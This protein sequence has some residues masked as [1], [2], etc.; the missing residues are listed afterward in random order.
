MFNNK[1]IKTV[2]RS[3]SYL[4]LIVCC[5]AMAVKP[6]DSLQDGESAGALRVVENLINESFDTL[7][8]ELPEGRNIFGAADSPASNDEDLSQTIRRDR[9]LHL[10]T[11]RRPGK[12]K[13]GELRKANVYYYDYQADETLHYIIELQTNRVVEVVKMTGVQLPLT[14]LEIETAVDIVMSSAEFKKELSRAFELTTGQ[15]FS[16][17]SQV[18]YK[19]FV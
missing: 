2:L 14:I 15:P 7:P 5:N 18:D 19:A 11:E 13:S 4:S 6:L 8:S 17:K 1:I 9:P 12:L 3:V 16:E 10:L